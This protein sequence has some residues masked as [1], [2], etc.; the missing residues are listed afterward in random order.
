MV[1]P[2]RSRSDHES[3]TRSYETEPNQQT[4]HWSTGATEELDRYSEEFATLVS[5][6]PPAPDEAPVDWLR[7]LPDEAFAYFQQ[8]VA[9]F[10]RKPQSPGQR[11]GRL[12]LLHTALVLMWIRWDREQ[13]EKKFRAEAQEGTRRTGRLT[14]LEYYRRGGVLV[15]YEVEDWL[16]QPVG[17]WSVDLSS[18]AVDPGALSNTSLREKMIDQSVVTMSLDQMRALLKMGAIPSPDAVSLS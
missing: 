14:T 11:R 15:D 3:S 4:Q 5:Q 18:A 1:T 8:G 7:R 10:G 16:Y 12:Y 6:W 9:T 17:E 2:N 13:A